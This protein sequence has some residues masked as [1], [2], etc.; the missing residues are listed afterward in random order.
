MPCKCRVQTD[1]NILQGEREGGVKTLKSHICVVHVRLR[2]GGPCTES[3]SNRSTS[4]V[5][6]KSASASRTLL[7]QRGAGSGTDF[8]LL[9]EVSK[10]A[11]ESCVY[12]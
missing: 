2:L 4:G 5:G 12:L 11:L 10:F 9:I 1:A 8:V 7:H 3:D 6:R